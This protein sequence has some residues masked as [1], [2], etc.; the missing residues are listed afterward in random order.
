MQL[1]AKRFA[2][3]YKRL[4][5]RTGHA[6]CYMCVAMQLPPHYAHCICTCITEYRD[7]TAA[8][9][10]AALHNKYLSQTLDI[11]N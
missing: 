3:D 4:H 1:P 11:Q 6:G 5:F 10:A 9:I 7:T 2:S 8:A